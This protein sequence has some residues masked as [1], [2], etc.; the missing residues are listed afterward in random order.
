MKSLGPER[1][2]LVVLKDEDLFAEFRRHFSARQF[3]LVHAVDKE[4]ALA[5]ASIRNLRLALVPLDTEG[6]EL[7][8]ALKHISTRGVR[9]I[10]TGTKEE[11]AS[12]ADS[13]LFDGLA[14]RADLELVLDRVRELLNERRKRPRVAV[15]FPVGLGD[16]GEGVAREVSANALVVTTMMPLSAGDQVAVEIG[17]GEEPVKFE[18]TV[19][20]ADRAL[21]GQTSLVLHLPEQ[22][23]EAREYL[24]QLVQKIFEVQHFLGG[25]RGPGGLD[26]EPAEYELEVQP[27][28]GA[29]GPEQEVRGLTRK[30]LESR[31]VLLEP[32]GR[33]GVGEVHRARHWHLKRRVAI[34]ILRRDLSHDRVAATRLEQEAKVATEVACPGVVDIIDYGKDPGRGP[35]Y[36]MEDLNGESLAGAI[37]SGRIFCALD[38]ARLGVHLATSLSAAHMLGFG[39]FDICPENI[40]LQSWSERRLWPLLINVAG[41][42]EG[43]S[44]TDSHPVGA[45]YW[46]PE[47]PSAPLG[48]G[49]DVYAL[50]SV[51]EMLLTRGA[52][53]AVGDGWQGAE[54]AQDQGDE[55][56]E[57]VLRRAK[58]QLPRARTPDMMVLARDL[59]SC[60]SRMELP[61]PSCP[62][63]V[64]ELP[65]DPARVFGGELP[66]VRGMLARAMALGLAS[67]ALPAEPQPTS[68]PPAAAPSAVPDPS[69]LIVDPAPGAR[70][71][72]LEPEVSDAADP[73]GRLA[74]L[75]SE[76]PDPDEIREPPAAV[77]PAPR[78]AAEPEPEPEPEPAPQLVAGEPAAKTMEIVSALDRTRTPM[79]AVWLLVLAVVLVGAVL[80]WMLRSQRAPRQTVPPAA[81][82]M[83]G[84]Q[85]PAPAPAG[86]QQ[87]ASA[88]AGEQQPAS[89]PAGEQQPAPAPAGEQ[90]PAPAPAGDQPDTEAPSPAIQGLSP[91]AR[92]RGY[93]RAMAV[94]N[95]ALRRGRLSD[96]ETLYRRAVQL[97]DTAKAR[98]QLA[99]VLERTRRLEQAIE[100]ITRAAA[101]EPDVAWYQDKLGR[102]QLKAGNRDKACEAF[103]TAIK[104]RAG[105]RA[106][107]RNLRK[108]CR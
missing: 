99:V 75:I 73:S 67:R 24:D 52:L 19:G 30:D 100:Q 89:A 98:A 31:Y 66:P 36:V 85:Q 39:H 107:K 26:A 51:L 72:E 44:L 63:P 93:L 27:E 62:Q 60:L 1:P 95:K 41:R 17:W 22:A 87:P 102:L 79:V 50:A 43:V 23:A 91:A 37:E 78:F 35:F 32:L 40:F 77:S 55:S 18:A 71:M 61:P 6:I 88:P 65:P 83:A 59:A 47:A 9:V 54:C 46:P 2:I 28:P 82:A 97:Q 86:E 20:R 81:P 49:Y 84:E 101:L 96:A 58:A 38:V 15:E 5:M 48:P 106:A 3:E 45:S 70:P 104:A 25:T 42:L 4:Q 68:P 8:G 21:L 13:H 29:A 103:R 10:G 64:I 56:L 7:A 94:G 76:F 34:K 90:Q 57:L 108:H 11:M 12:V 105:Y 33:W 14:P 16:R 80:F 74:E 92:K 69:L 53:E